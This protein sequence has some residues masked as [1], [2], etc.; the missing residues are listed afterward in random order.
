VIEKKYHAKPCL[1]GPLPVFKGLRRRV[2]FVV[3]VIFL[4]KSLALK[5]SKPIFGMP[6]HENGIPKIKRRSHDCF[7]DWFRF[8]L[9]R[10]A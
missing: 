4:Q 2:Q 5:K 10:T 6:K 3:G 9:I 8:S 7:H 1:K